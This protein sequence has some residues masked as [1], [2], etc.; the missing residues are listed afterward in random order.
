MTI[1]YPTVMPR[2]PNDP[3]LLPA[4]YRQ[5][6]SYLLRETMRCTISQRDKVGFGLMACRPG[7]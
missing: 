1:D 4:E 2:R 3:N 7:V 5:S 6:S